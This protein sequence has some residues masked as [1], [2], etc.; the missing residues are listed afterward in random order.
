MTAVGLE[1]WIAIIVPVVT[2]L[3]GLFMPSPSGPSQPPTPPKPVLGPIDSDD[4][5]QLLAAIQEK[6]RQMRGG[7]VA[8]GQ[9]TNPILDTLAKLIKEK[10]ASEQAPP[11]PNP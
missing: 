11:A 10:L 6:F 4:I 8:P 5:P 1:F 2:G 3:I 7:Q 9:S